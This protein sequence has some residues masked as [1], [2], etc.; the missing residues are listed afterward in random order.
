MASTDKNADKETPSPKKPAPAKASAKGAAP[1]DARDKILAD[2]RPKQAAP[3]SGPIQVEWPN[4]NQGAIAQCAM[5]GA[6]MAVSFAG[7]FG[8]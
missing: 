3:L 1:K 8:A 7:P 5:D 4:E 6:A 2:A